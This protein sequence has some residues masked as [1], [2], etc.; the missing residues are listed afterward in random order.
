MTR[1]ICTIADDRGRLNISIWVVGKQHIRVRGAVIGFMGL[2]QSDNC[3]D[4]LN[5]SISRLAKLHS[6]AV[7]GG[8]SGR[9][10]NTCNRVWCSRRPVR[11]IGS[12][13]GCYQKRGWELV[14]ISSPR[15][16][17]AEPACRR[18]AVEWPERAWAT[19]LITG[20]WYLVDL[21]TALDTGNSLE[22]TFS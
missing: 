15:I 13:G 19:A 17:L 6:G 20:S 22:S 11:N 7:I 4:G 21:S 8:S 1:G 12:C 14:Q 9:Q 18:A 2:R 16:A 10:S 5:G 3:R